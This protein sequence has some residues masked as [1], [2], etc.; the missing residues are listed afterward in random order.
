M[1]LAFYLKLYLAAFAA[2]LVIDLIW[3]GLIANKLYNQY[4][5]Y[6]MAPSVNWAAA[7][8]FYLLWIAGLLILAVIPGLQAKSPAKAIFFG[9]LFGFMTYATYDLTNLATV[10]D[11]PLLITIIDLIWGTTLATA[12]STISF[13]VGRRLLR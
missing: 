5:G 7:I 10:K 1:K 8:L 13:L 11:W 4:L 9:A 6:L 3:L 2:F 12:V